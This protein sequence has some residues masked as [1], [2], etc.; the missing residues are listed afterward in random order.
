M[1]YIL[2]NQS[3]REK[4]IDF[5]RALYKEDNLVSNERALSL[6][7]SKFP[8]SNANTRCISIWKNKLRKEGI[9][10]PKSKMG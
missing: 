9:N 1:V 8:D 2:Q 4:K 10:I 6:L 7:L 3:K 5:L